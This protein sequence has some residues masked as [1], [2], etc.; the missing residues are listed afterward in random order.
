MTPKPGDDV[1]VEFEGLEHRG[2]VEKVERGWV[3]CTIKVDPEAD[4]GAI[5]S[6]MSPYQTVAVKSAKVRPLG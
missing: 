1:I 6:R 5:T 3:F 2:H 4:Y